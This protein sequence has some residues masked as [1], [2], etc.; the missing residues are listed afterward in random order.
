VR[1]KIK[2]QRKKIGYT[3]EQMGLKLGYTRA[4]YNRL[5]QGGTFFTSLDDIEKL[6][7]ILEISLKMHE[8]EQNSVNL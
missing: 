4:K 8:N 1:T 3:Q 6:F 5:E 7:E 2:Q